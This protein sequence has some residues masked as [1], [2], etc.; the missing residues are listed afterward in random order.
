MNLSHSTAPSRRGPI[1]GLDRPLGLLTLAGVA[2]FLSGA[3]AAYWP[4]IAAGLFFLAA[5]VDSAPNP[6]TRTDG[7]NRRVAAFFLWTVLAWGVS[8]C[9][10]AGTESVLKVGIFLAF[11]WLA[12]RWNDDHRRF[13]KI[14]VLA[15]ALAYSA[16][17]VLGT[18]FPSLTD[19][20]LPR[21]P[22]Y[23]S[24]WLVAGTLMVLPDALGLSGA[25]PQKASG[26]ARRAAGWILP[27]FFLLGLLLFRSRSGLIAVSVGAGALIHRRWGAR[28]L[29]WFVL[30]LAAAAVLAPVS[31]TAAVLK[32]MDPFGWSRLAIW[33][34][35]AAGVLDRPLFG[36]GPGLFARL[37]G[38]HRGP[39]PHQWIR[40]DHDHSFAHN[41]FLQLAAEYGLPALLLAGAAFGPALTRARRAADPT[42]WAL[43]L[44]AAVFC[45][46][47]FPFYSPVN[48][49][50]AAGVFFGLSPE[51]DRFS[52]PVGRDRALWRAAF[53]VLGGI[54]LGAFIA[55]RSDR[56]GFVFTKAQLENRLNRADALV[57]P[58]VGGTSDPAEAEALLREVLRRW[59]D[60]PEAGHAL[61]HLLIEHRAPP[62]LEEGLPWLTR[63]SILQ[64]TRATWWM[65]L[66]GAQATLG[67]WPDALESAQN[68]L[69]LE[70]E[71]ADAQWMIARALTRIG[72]PAEAERF[73]AP[74]RA[75]P[76]EDS[77]S[78]SGYGRTIAHRDRD[79]YLL[80]SAYA[81]LRLH[82][83][84][85]ALTFLSERTAPPSAE[86]LALAVGAYLARRDRPSARRLW[87]DL[88]KGFPESPAVKLLA[89][90]FEA[91]NGKA[92]KGKIRATP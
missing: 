9:P 30:S 74:L 41:D 88:R 79:A 49:L 8:L 4:L 61:G 59:P 6:G 54:A 66:S 77:A 72:D 1:A 22:Q 19:A 84:T 15:G 36:W 48:L 25:K 42:R 46:F 17:A 91:V 2:V 78:L 69:R 14:L 35:A 23:K 40:F 3:R 12:S 80:E 18:F 27:A 76:P 55:A 11:G 86:S 51:P 65:E 28:G 43:L 70:P 87:N 85:A 92:P 81:Q 44:S 62:K 31:R 47:N 10:P 32:T 26:V 64:P 5:F 29:L 52:P 38:A 39:F 53:A 83:P 13:F 57:H 89:E 21:N 7:R 67:R 37:Y 68:A 82:N 60:H 24:F 75:L 73:L 45:V 56:G 33:K 16:G 63:A 58:P 71:Y 90:A 34:A 50:L 20:G